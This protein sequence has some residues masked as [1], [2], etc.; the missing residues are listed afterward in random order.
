[1][2]L[3]RVTVYADFRRHSWPIF[4]ENKEGAAVNHNGERYRDMLTVRDD[5]IPTIRT[6]ITH[7]SLCTMVMR[8]NPQE[9][10]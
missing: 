7:D 5:L 10:M 4:F 8:I 6:H 1:M 3:Q 9:A 2:H